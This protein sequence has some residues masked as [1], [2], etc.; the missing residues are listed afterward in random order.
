MNLRAAAARRVQS[1]AP[2]RQYRL[3]LARRT[4]QDFAAGRALRLL[5]AGC[6]DGLL[7]A[8]LARENPNWTVVGGDINE[9]ALQKAR[10]S[11]AREGLANVEYVHLDVTRPFAEGEYDAV[12]AVE[13][14]AEIPDDTGAV[15]AFAHALR[16]GGLLVV[17]VPERSW[18]PVLPGSPKV[19][20]RE[21]RHGYGA[22]ELRKLLE[23]AGLEAIEIRP[24]T[25]ATLHAAEEI[26]A[27]TKNSRLRVRA[28]VYPALT[29][30]IRLERLGFTAGAA[31]ALLA[32][33]RKP[34]LTAQA[35]S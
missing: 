29:A 35:A 25:R 3:D 12:A 2:G 8:T 5:D 16:P 23:D 22:D 18:S 27:R 6:E 28:A 14:L 20:Q 9:E 31:R 1:F 21:A 10:T 4:L 32:T 24:T 11:S 30:A 7:A 19:W 33:A 13:C 34:A 26:R 15:D 17:H